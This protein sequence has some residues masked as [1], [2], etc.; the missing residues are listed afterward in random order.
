MDVG[1]A[2]FST[3]PQVAVCLFIRFLFIGSRLRS[4]LLSDPDSRRRRCASLSLLLHQDVKKTSASK[5]SNRLGTRK[6]AGARKLRL[7]SWLCARIK[8]KL[9]ET[10]ATSLPRLVCLLARY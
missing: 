9:C 4:T 7:S 3:L 8:P 2:A 6:K 5:L 1:F 10:R